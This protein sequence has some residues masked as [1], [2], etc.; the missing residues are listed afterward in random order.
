[1]QLQMLTVAKDMRLQRCPRLASVRPQKSPTHQNLLF[2]SQPPTGRND[3]TIHLETN[4]GVFEVSLPG[5][6]LVSQQP[7]D[8]QVLARSC[9]SYRHHP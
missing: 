9:T 4:G 3:Q 1:M 2:L 5:N 6:S 8:K 7:G